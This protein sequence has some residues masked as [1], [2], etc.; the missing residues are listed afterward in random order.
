[1]SLSTRARR[2][3]TELTPH[4]TP[5][6]VRTPRALSSSATACNF[7][8][9]LALISAMMGGEF[10]CVCVG[11]HLA[12]LGPDTPLWPKSIAGRSSPH[13]PGLPNAAS[14][15]LRTVWPAR[16]PGLNL[17][18]SP[19]AERP[20]WRA[21]GRVLEGERAADR[22]QHRGRLVLPRRIRQIRAEPAS[23]SSSARPNSSTIDVFLLF[24]L[25]VST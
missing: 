10:Y 3:N 24:V 19:G 15:S 2:R 6:A 21:A 18:G 22:Y 9:P 7:I 13:A 17:T 8:A 1:L 20:H 16:V 4:L 11:F 23:A 12:S 5:I 14:H 25:L